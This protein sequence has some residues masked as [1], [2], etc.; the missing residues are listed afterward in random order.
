MNG[1]TDAASAFPQD[2]FLQ[3]DVYKMKRSG[4]PAMQI[5]TLKF[6]LKIN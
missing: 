1:M 6:A 4:F 5:P 3:T 2:D